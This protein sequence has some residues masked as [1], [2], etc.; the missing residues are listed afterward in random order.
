MKGDIRISKKSALLLVGA[1]SIFAAADFVSIVDSKTAGGVK[2]EKESQPIGSIVFRMD[3]VNPSTI[4][5]G[6]WSLLKG[7]AS[8]RLG[9]GS[10]QSATLKG[11]ANDQVV[12]L[13]AHTHTM[14]HDHPVATTSTDTHDHNV[15]MRGSSYTAAAAPS[16]HTDT[17]TVYPGITL[18]NGNK[19]YESR[20]AID[21]DSHNHTVDLPNFVGNTGSAGTANVTMDVRGQY[22][23]LNVWQR[24]N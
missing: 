22:L 14:N 23:T 8:I 21:N 3:S 12:P 15:S 17:N 24:V 20:G 16:W 7:D 19:S 13:V 6:T 10:G 1:L 4:Y 2:V 11:N 9:D 5:G 18:T